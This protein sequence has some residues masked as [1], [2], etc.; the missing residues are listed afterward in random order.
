MT[1]TSVIHQVALGKNSRK[2]FW[3]LTGQKFAYGQKDQLRATGLLT[4]ISYLMPALP[5]VYTSAN[6]PGIICVSEG[7]GKSHGVF[8]H[9]ADK[10]RFP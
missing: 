5:Q 10:Q 1:D 2:V 9:V 7:I 8:L 4:L 3:A 6:R